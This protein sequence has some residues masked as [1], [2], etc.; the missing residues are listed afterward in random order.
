M[1]HAACS[2]QLE[3]AAPGQAL[4]PIHR[5]EPAAPGQALTFIYSLQPAAPGQALTYI[6]SLQPASP[7]QA[8]SPIY[9]LQPTWAKRSHTYIAGQPVLLV[10]LSLLID[11]HAGQFPC[12]PCII[13]PKSRACMIS[14]AQL[15]PTATTAASTDIPARDPSLAA[16]WAS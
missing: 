3:L 4:T 2:W 13:E 11:L 15:P 12:L 10:Q 9:S 1:Q 5:L 7:G 6:C 16:E 8:L 14:V